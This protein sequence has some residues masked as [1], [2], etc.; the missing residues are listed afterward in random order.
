MALR[1]EKSAH[2]VG[3]V[4]VQSQI[5][6]ELERQKTLIYKLDGDHKHLNHRVT[7]LFDKVKKPAGTPR[8]ADF[9]RVKVQVEG[10]AKDSQMS[11]QQIT[12]LQQQLAQ[13]QQLQQM[14]ELTKAELERTVQS[15]SMQAQQMM[16]QMHEM[17]QGVQRLDE[18][19]QLL[20]KY[21]MES[22]ENKRAMDELKRLLEDQQEHHGAK[23]ELHSKVQDLHKEVKEIKHI[24]SEVAETKVKHRKLETS[25]TKLEQAVSS[26]PATE[27]QV[28]TLQVDV[29]S[30]TR[31]LNHLRKQIYDA[32]VLRPARPEVVEQERPAVGTIDLSEDVFCARLLLRLGFVKAAKEEV[33][34]LSEELSSDDERHHIILHDEDVSGLQPPLLQEGD[35]GYDYVT[36]GWNGICAFTLVVQVVI[37]GIMLQYG[38]HQVETCEVSN[39]TGSSWWTL[40]MSKLLATVLAGVLMGKDI[41]D[42]VNYWM[43]SQLLEGTANWETSLTAFVRLVLAILIGF[44]N[45]TIYESITSAAEVWMNMAALAFIGE[46]GQGVLLVAKG[47]I[48]GHHIAKEMTAINFQLTFLTEYPRWFYF[49]RSFTVAST[50]AFTSIYSVLVFVHSKC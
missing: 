12:A 22:V 9:E 37:V 5:V 47:G 11:Q 33:A 49:A 28:R 13:M 19:R 45:V 17:Q 8:D 34:E 46:I 35:I 26:R 44:A 24:H 36:T 16:R 3:G 18:V 27:N 25:L 2:D 48:F 21:E 15:Q 43:V 14:T 10:V 7:E 38:L 20:H 39:V 40:H 30:T 42:I 29:T 23:R 6:L 1:K 31:D 4:P 32:G 41:M 50:F